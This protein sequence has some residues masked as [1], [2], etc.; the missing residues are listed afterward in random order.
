M[1]N[2]TQMATAI[3]H[4]FKEHSKSGSTLSPMCQRILAV[5]SSELK[6]IPW[7][8]DASAKRTPLEVSLLLISAVHRQILLDSQ[9]TQNLRDY[10]P[11]VGGLKSFRDASFAP[12]FLEVLHEY[13]HEIIKAIQSETVQTNETQ[14][15]LFWLFPVILTGWKEIHLVDLGASAGLNL[16]ADKRRFTWSDG[17]RT[18]SFGSA[19]NEQFMSH[20]TPQLPEFWIQE[21]DIPIVL[22]RNGCDISPFPLRDEYDRAK[23]ESFVWP[24]QLNRFARLHEGIKAHSEVSKVQ[25]ISIDEVTLPHGLPEYL[26]SLNFSDGAPVVVYNTY[27]TT[28]LENKGLA[29]RGYI[30]DWARSYNRKVLWIQSEPAPGSPDNHHWCAWTADLWDGQMGEYHWH[31][32]WVHPHGTE[33]DLLQDLDRFESFFRTSSLRT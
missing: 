32:G 23:L 27:M 26:N 18:L 33:I 17:K 31:V 15:G 20:V 10:Y 13:K 19:V 25:D 3:L 21:R 8:V 22:S 7:L 5:V 30:G 11:S 28:Y 9:K 6:N 12:L 2:R 1:M 14:R 4:Y 24:D 29:M 16:V